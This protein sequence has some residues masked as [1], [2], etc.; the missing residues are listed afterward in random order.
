M[1]EALALSNYRLPADWERQEAVWFAWPTHNN[2]WPSHLERVQARMAQLFCMVADF[3]PVYVLCPLEN[4]SGLREHLVGAEVMLFDYRCDDVWCRDFG[5]LFLLNKSTQNLLVSDWRFNAWGEKYTPWT[6]DDQAA[7]WIANALKLSIKREK[8][9][10]EGGA[11]ECNGAQVLLTTESVLLNSNR[12]EVFEKATIERHLMEGLGISCIHWLKGGLAGDDTDGHIDNV[13]RFYAEDAILYAAVPDAG[14]K[15]HAILA[16]NEQ[17]IRQFTDSNGKRYRTKAL[18]MPDTIFVD[19]QIAAASYLNYLVLNGAVI[20]PS[21]GQTDKEGEVHCILGECYP[22]RKILSF[23]C[24]D[25]IREGGAL[26][27][28]SQHQPASA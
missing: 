7:A 18:P 8:Y 24:R 25:I 19:G 12:G 21:Y 26:H 11:I 22:G 3:Q 10:L 14:H 20:F 15:D 5:P 17:L 27:C 28:L 6:R 1:S 16:E 23:D 2:L 13:A 9:V 4:H